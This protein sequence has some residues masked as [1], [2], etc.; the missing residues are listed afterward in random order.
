M[1]T[2]KQTYNQTYK[3]ASHDITSHRRICWISLVC[4]S[5]N[6]Y[7]QVFSFTGFQDRPTR[8]SA[9]ARQTLIVNSYPLIVYGSSIETHRNTHVVNFQYES[10]SLPGTQRL[11]PYRIHIFD[12][13]RV[14]TPLVDQH[15]QQLCLSERAC[16]GR[17]G[18][19]PSYS[20]ATLVRVMCDGARSLLRSPGIA[21]LTSYS[22]PMTI[23]NS[24]LVSYAAK[25]LVNISSH[26]L[27]TF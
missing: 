2:Y 6:L 7:D 27:T 16:D 15:Q 3:H 10:S 18:V 26:E 23:L 17:T 20:H 12:T 4:G 5:Q 11:N 19:C 24:F 9:V 25:S 14:P 21:R 8:S 13:Q 1:R 22:H